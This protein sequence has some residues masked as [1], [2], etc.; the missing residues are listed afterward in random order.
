MCASELAFTKKDQAFYATLTSQ[1]GQLHRLV[2]PTVFDA[3]PGSCCGSMDDPA[4]NAQWLIL[5]T[6]KVGKRKYSAAEL[7]AQSN[8]KAAMPDDLLAW[9]QMLPAGNEAL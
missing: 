9:E 7:N 1:T 5:L 6:P 4:Q 3:R 8:L 2:A